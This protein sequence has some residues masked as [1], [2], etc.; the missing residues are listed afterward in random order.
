MENASATTKTRKTWSARRPVSTRGL[1]LAECMIASVVLAVSTS[2]IAGALAA[3]YQ[4]QR[5]AQNASTAAVASERLLEELLA[6]PSE[7]AQT[8]DDRHD[9]ADTLD[10]RT[11]TRTLTGDSA[12]LNLTE[13]QSALNVNA[14][15]AESD[16]EDDDSERSGSATTRGPTGPASIDRA[17]DTDKVSRRVRVVR[18]NAPGGSSVVD[19]SL[20]LVEVETTDV[21]GGVVR[22]KRLISE[23]ESTF[24]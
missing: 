24:R 23:T 19:G 4:H 11:L 14:P 17:S 6:L 2:A 18:K 12:A 15:T 7:G 5:A 20:V 8:L 1:G 16:D 9:Y 10:T 13:A 21:D 3:S 22:V